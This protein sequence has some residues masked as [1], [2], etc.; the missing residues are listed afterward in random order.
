MGATRIVQ[1]VICVGGDG[2]KSCS[3]RGSNYLRT[4]E[5]EVRIA[6][7]VARVA[8]VLGD[9]PL[10]R[11]EWVRRNPAAQLRRERQRRRTN[12]LCNR[13]GGQ[14]GGIAAAAM[15]IRLA[16]AHFRRSDSVPERPRAAERRY[17]SASPR[18]PRRSSSRRTTRPATSEVSPAVTA[19]IDNTPPA[20]V[21]VGVEGGEAW[22]NT[23]D[24][25]VAWTNPPEGDRA[26]IVAASYKLCPA[27]AGSC[28]R[29][30][31]AGD[32]PV[33]LRRCSARA[34]RVHSVTLAPGCRWE[35]D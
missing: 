7:V 17:D 22:R 20:R 23:N 6:D 2:R 15:R 5:A 32:E 30:E 26:P 14:T 3:A 8:S 33:A 31:Q 35:R 25:V 9:T 10:G 16:R 29:G 27:G 28:S 11:G 21:D 18:A 19:R 13:L 1:R 4:Y 24:F 12:G 34:G